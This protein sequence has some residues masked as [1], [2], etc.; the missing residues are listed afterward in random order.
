MKPATISGFSYA[1]MFWQS[2]SVRLHLMKLPFIRHSRCICSSKSFTVENRIWLKFLLSFYWKDVIR[3][4]LFAAPLISSPFHFLHSNDFLNYF[5]SISAF[6]FSFFYIPEMIRV[7]PTFRF[8]LASVMT[9]SCL[10]M[11]N[12]IC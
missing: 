10:K 5:V 1:S 7:K 12:Y 6:F 2:T 8:H 3:L 4:L 9:F 11:Q